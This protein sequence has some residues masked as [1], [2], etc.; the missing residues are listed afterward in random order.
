MFGYVANVRD[1]GIEFVCRVKIVVALV[2]GRS[3]IVSEP[4]VIAAA[5]KAD[6]ADGRSAFRGG[7]QGTADD[8]LVDVAEGA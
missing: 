8:G 5:V 7:F 4:G 6:I 2:G 1:P 3:G